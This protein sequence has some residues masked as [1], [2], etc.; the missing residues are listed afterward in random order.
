MFL[1]GF[2]WKKTTAGAAMFATI[3][4]LAGS[5]VLKFLPQMMD[6]SFLVP[7]GFAK[8]TEA[9][10]AEIPFLDRMFIVF[11]CV[12]AGMVL[13]SK[14]AEARREGNTKALHIDTSLFRVDGAFAVGS[15]VI[16]VAL[17]AIYGVGW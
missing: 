9:G 13:M 2:F 12:V 8:V 17:A 4:G 3:G 10:V 6:L 14:L 15:A 5:I 16:G 7:I 11:W 1:M